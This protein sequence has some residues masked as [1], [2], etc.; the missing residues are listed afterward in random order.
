[1][2]LFVNVYVYVERR[3]HPLSKKLFDSLIVRFELPNSNFCIMFHIRLF[4]TWGQFPL[5][6]RMY[7]RI[8]VSL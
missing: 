1:M 4:V 5:Q 6:T 7:F 3:V 8:R 2:V